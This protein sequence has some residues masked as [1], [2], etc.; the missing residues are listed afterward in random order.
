M[1]CSDFLLLSVLLFG[2]NNVCCEI[3]YYLWLTVVIN[4]FV[5]KIIRIKEEEEEEG[6]M[7]VVRKLN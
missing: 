4:P 2:V 7:D 6:G 5:I 1:R 3:L